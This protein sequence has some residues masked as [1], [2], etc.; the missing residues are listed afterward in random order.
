MKLNRLNDWSVEVDIPLKPIIYVNKNIDIEKSALEELETFSQID[1]IKKLSLT[2]DFHRGSGTPIGTVAL[3]DR[4]YPKV[5]G[6]DIGCGIRLDVLPITELPPMEVLIPKLRH[7]FFEG[8]R[9]IFIK[10]RSSVLLG[11][12]LSENLY[13]K[14][15]EGL[16]F[17]NQQFLY[18]SGVSDV[19]SP[20]FTIKSERDNIL[21]TI[22]GGNHFVEIQRVSEI[23]DGGLAHSLKIKPGS[24]C[25]MVHSGSLDNGHQVGNHFKDLAKS[26]FEGKHPKNGYFPLNEEDSHRY[27]IASANTSNFAKINRAI[28]S[29]MVAQV[30]GCEGKFIYDSHHNLILPHAEEYLHLKGACRA[31]ENEIVLIPG[32]M[33]S[34]SFVGI[35]L[36]FE[37]TSSCAPHGAGRVLNRGDS[38]KNVEDLKEIN[39]VTKI[40]PKRIRKDVAEEVYKSIAEESPRSYKDVR[41][42]IST[43]EMAGIV[44][45]A[46]WLEPILTIKG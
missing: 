30:L 44:K 43:C 34:S 18:S 35:G 25:V 12:G 28:M 46:F 10:D 21:G 42:V 23:K 45:Q 22:G 41:E 27:M 26:K 14:S 6:N 4:V 9:E 1:G 2:P 32:S 38:R 39:I 15:T 33:G 24:Y 16:D 36:G 29:N 13:G 40:D 11:D 8:G 31:T 3:I 5:P 17:K 37:G 20:Y 19:L 7:V